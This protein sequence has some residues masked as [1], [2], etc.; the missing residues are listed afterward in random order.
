[1]SVQDKFS[2]VGLRIKAACL[3]ARIFTMSDAE[4][5][6]QR[7]SDHQDAQNAQRLRVIE[8]G[9]LSVYRCRTPFD[10]QAERMVAPKA[11]EPRLQK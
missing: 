6:Q 2:A 9:P 5:A 4:R 8:P 7:R 3:A 11:Q 10:C 1:M